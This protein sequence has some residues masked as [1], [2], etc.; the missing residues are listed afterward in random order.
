MLSNPIHSV[1]VRPSGERE[2]T[3]VAPD[4]RGVELEIIAVEVV[5]NRV[6]VIHV[7]PTALMRRSHE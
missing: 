2:F 6:L 7:I 5:E 3:W 1:D 4:D